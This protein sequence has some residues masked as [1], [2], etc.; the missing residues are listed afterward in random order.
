VNF[1][2]EVEGLVVS[3]VT[4]G[5]LEQKWNL[6]TP[7]LLFIKLLQILASHRECVAPR[8]IL[9]TWKAIVDVGLCRRV[10]LIQNLVYQLEYLYD[11]VGACGFF[12]KLSSLC[13]KLFLKGVLWRLL[14]SVGMQ[15]F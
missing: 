10:Q 6:V 15:A 5:E 11:K 3:R 8:Q 4:Q 14:W 13:C 12:A 9:L 7:T 1:E 2:N